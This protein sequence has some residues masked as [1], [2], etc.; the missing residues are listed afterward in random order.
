MAIVI[1]IFIINFATYLPDIQQN[2]ILT[3]QFIEQTFK[4]FNVDYFNNELPMPKF[5]ITNTHRMLGQCCAK[6][7]RSPHPNFFIKISNH[8]DRRSHDFKNTI[9][10]EMIH[11]FFQS[12]GMWKVGHGKEFQQMARSFDKYGWNIQT[13]EKINL[14]LNS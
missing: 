6:N 8:F 1:R 10:H 13:K 11:L 2:M 12:K 3:I 7:W 4:R 9:L 5:Q 14:K